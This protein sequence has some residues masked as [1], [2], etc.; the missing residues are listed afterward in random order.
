MIAVTLLHLNV[1]TL[2]LTAFRCSAYPYTSVIVKLNYS[3]LVSQLGFNA[4]WV[5]PSPH[6]AVSLPNLKWT[7]SL[8]PVTNSYMKLQNSIFSY[9]VNGRFIEVK[10]KWKRMY[11]DIIYFRSFH[12][13][14]TPNGRLL[15]LWLL[16]CAAFSL[17]VLC[18]LLKSSL[19]VTM[20]RKSFFLWKINSLSLRYHRIIDLTSDLEDY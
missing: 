16:F 15:S 8:G 5:P 14:L 20:R 3:E 13:S 1:I 7:S 4:F 12:W 11:R 17:C 10:S 6:L 18:S 9:E 19:R 2:I